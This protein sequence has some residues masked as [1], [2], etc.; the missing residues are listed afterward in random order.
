[1]LALATGLSL[2]GIATTLS[3]GA[4]PRASPASVSVE[5]TPVNPAPPEADPLTSAFPV[6]LTGG[7]AIVGLTRLALPPQTER[8][9]KMVSGTMMLIVE[10][11]AVDLSS[12]DGDR[13][14]TDSLILRHGDQT[15]LASGLV[16]IV[17][18]TS[19]LPAT[20]L[21]VTIRSATV[22]LSHRQAS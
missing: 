4:P 7:A 12:R 15:V 9:L 14:D 19:A 11:G 17:K 10:S 18:N 13:A 2:L 16:N 5:S 21:V 3:S 6:N 22:P 20:V 8:P 1:M